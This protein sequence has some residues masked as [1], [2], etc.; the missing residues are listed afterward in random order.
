MPFDKKYKEGYS[1]EEKIEVFRQLVARQ[2]QY[3][4][5]Q[6]G[7][8]VFITN[9]TEIKKANPDIP[10]PEGWWRGCPRK[11]QRGVKNE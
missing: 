2:R 4:Q 11:K 10:I 3:P 6:R 7:G 9:G 1:R 8:Y 5:T